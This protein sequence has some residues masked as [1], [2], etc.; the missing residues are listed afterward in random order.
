MRQRFSVLLLGILF[1][2][3]AIARAATVEVTVRNFEFVPATININPGDTVIWNAVQGAHDVVANDG[4]FSS[5]A[6]KQAP[7]TFSHKFNTEGTFRYFCSPHQGFGM[8]GT[9]VVGNGG[10]ATTPVYTVCESR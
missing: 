2:N 10:L 5:G 7:W 4:S 9:I 1:L 3:A 6:V 8:V